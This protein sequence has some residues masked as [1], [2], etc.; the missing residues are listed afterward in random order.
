M[1]APTEVTTPEMFIGFILQL[2]EAGLP[3]GTRELL[4]L[5]EAL[6]RGV[7]GTSTDDFYYLCRSLFVKQ[8]QALDKFDRA[9]AAAF[10]D[11]S[12][13]PFDP[14]A[15]IPEDWLAKNKQLEG[16]PEEEQQPYLQELFRQLQERF[17]QLLKDQQ[18]RHEG[19]NKWIGTGGR[20][21]FG[22]WGYNQQGYRL[23]QT[24]S[25]HKRAVKVWDQREFADLDDSRQLDTRQ[26]QLALRRLRL[27]SHSGAPE[28][29]D[30]EET[31]RKTCQNA[32]VLR[33]VYRPQRS[34]G[35]RLLLFLDVGGSMDEHV[36]L[37]EQLFS[38]A[39]HEFQ[40]LEHFYFHNCLYEKVWKDSRRR[41]SEYMSTESL[42][43]RYRSDY[44]VIVV[45]DASMSPY[46]LLY[47]GGSVEHLNE[48][49]GALWLQRLR[50]HFPHTIWLN[51]VPQSEWS[52][53]ETI[54]QIKALF[55]EHM[56]PL[57]LKGL[58]Q[59]VKALR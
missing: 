32:G 54:G 2:R 47:K 15:E 10:A 44:R 30:V 48:E 18:E 24:E 51:P 46:E 6:A 17:Q 31:I 1:A 55:E 36:R 26:F 42:F 52:Y 33:E 29:F 9:F 49:P 11:L 12:T 59:A 16:L 37:C 22:A 8:E 14:L 3:V 34:N 4:Y 43:Q 27:L 38:A 28:V 57:S 40:Q 13:L 19:G 20:S 35:L 25:R 39:R 58:E 7:V 5:Q 45:G 23:G 21:P 50:Q 56:Y 41:R 53:T